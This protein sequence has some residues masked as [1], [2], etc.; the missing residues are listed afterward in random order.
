[1][2]GTEERLRWTQRALQA[3]LA[4]LAGCRDCPL[5]PPRMMPGQEPYTACELGELCD[6]VAEAAEGDPG[7]AREAV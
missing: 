5:A 2:N 4:E 1:M 6:L 7:E 3:A